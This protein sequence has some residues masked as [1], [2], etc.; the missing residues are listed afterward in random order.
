MESIDNYNILY[1]ACANVV[2]DIDDMSGAGSLLEGYAPPVG[3]ADAVTTTSA[4]SWS[5]RLSKYRESSG[6]LVA[7]G[8]AYTF[9]LPLLCMIGTLGEKYIPLH[10][11]AADLRVEITWGPTTAVILAD[12]DD[13]PGGS[14]TAAVSSSQYQPRNL[15][16]ANTSVYGTTSLSYGT[17]ITSPTST[18]F[19]ITAIFLHC[20]MIQISDVSFSLSTTRLR[21]STRCTAGKYSFTRRPLFEPRRM[22]KLRWTP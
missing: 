9:Q 15:L 16:A 4:T 12:F 7:S 19:A 8:V 14:N 21:R 2:G 22:P 10:A 3:V 1:Q 6:M 17:P 18:T 13:Y 20:T 11:L 5:S